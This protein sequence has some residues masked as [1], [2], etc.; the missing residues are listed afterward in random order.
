MQFRF[1]IP[2]Q[3][4]GPVIELSLQ[5]AEKILLKK[6]E[7]PRK[8]ASGLFSSAVSK[9]NFGVRRQAK[10]DAAFPLTQNLH[11]ALALLRGMTKR[12]PV[13]S[14]SPR[15]R[16]GVRGKGPL[17]NLSLTKSLNSRF[18]ESLVS[19]RTSIVTTGHL[20]PNAS[21]AS[22]LWQSQPQKRQCQALWYRPQINRH[23]VV[24]GK[25]RPRKG[26]QTTRHIP[27]ILA[28]NKE[29]PNRNHISSRETN[30]FLF[31]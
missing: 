10:R 7:T 28:N 5:E 24:P 4:P 14:L 2:R 31:S 19:L 25:L 18:V 29:T 22:L 20:L 3:P 11:R 13:L 27:A 21:P 1:E 30:I 6:L 26:R 16:A 12:C 17:A 8:T 9:R 23:Y 15:E